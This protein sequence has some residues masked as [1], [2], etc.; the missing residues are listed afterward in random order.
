MYSLDEINESLEKDK[1][2]DALYKIQRFAKEQGLTDLATWCSWELT[3]YPS[4]QDKLS[5]SKEQEVREYR[6]LVVQWK[7]IYGNSMLIDPKL[8]FIHKVPI[9]LGITELE[10]YLGKGFDYSL[11]SF[12]EFL[13][14]YATVPVGEAF[15]GPEATQVLFD[16]I[17][18]KAR[19][20]L[21]D[22]VPRIPGR[23]L[24]YPAPNFA[25]LVADTE[26]AR[27]LGRRWRE[28]NLSFEAGAYLATVILLGSILEG[29]LLSKVE[30]NPA[31]ANKASKCPKDRSGKPLLFTDWKLQSLIEVAHECGWLKKYHKDFS[32]LVRDYRNFVHPN[33]ERQEGVTFDQN[34]CRVV[35]EAVTAALC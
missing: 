10:G 11:P 35:W 31:Q 8:S 21:H 26:L 29:V 16:R 33:K 4:G 25:T 18:L 30:Q 20:K 28:A 23:K 12:K 14:Q 13:S 3:G 5:E 15:V 7:D 1:L 19:S 9:Y 27:V 6:Y 34:I 22:N 24:V 2:S 32:H 17:R